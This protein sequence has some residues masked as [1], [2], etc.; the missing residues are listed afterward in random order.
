MQLQALSKG[1]YALFEDSEM[2]KITTKHEGKKHP[3]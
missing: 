1:A 2:N 3:G